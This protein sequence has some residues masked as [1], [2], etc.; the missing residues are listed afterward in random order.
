MASTTTSDSNKR[1]RGGVKLSGERKAREI[2]HRGPD[3]ERSIQTEEL[4][5]RQFFG[6]GVIVFINLWELLVTTDLIPLGGTIEHLLWS[7]MFLKTYAKQKVLC[8]LAG[9]VSDE[10]FR[11]WTWN[12]ILAIADLESVVVS[13]S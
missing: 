12:F 5:F 2:W 7:L 4:E 10:T 1:Q 6:C 13:S 3:K 11:K 9:G 8:S